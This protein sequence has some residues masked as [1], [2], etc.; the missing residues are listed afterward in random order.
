MWPILLTLALS[1]SEVRSEIARDEVVVFY[2]TYGRR[3]DDGKQ[4]VLDV[5]G[6]IFEPEENSLKRAALIG[7]LRRGLGLTSEHAETAIFRQRAQ[8]FLVDNEGNKTIHV[9]LGEKCY[10]SEPS[11]PNGHFSLTVTLD[12]SEVDKLAAKEAGASRHLTIRAITPDG[13]DREFT[14]RVNLIEPRGWSVIS[15]VD[16]TIKESNVTNPRVLLAN[17]FLREFK[18]VK[19]MSELYQSWAQRGA[20]FHYVSASPWQLFRPLEEFRSQEDF[21]AGS[22]QM[23]HFRLKDTS[24]LR[25]IA[26]QRGYKPAVLEKILKH[27]PE[28]KFV[29][30]GDDGEEDPEIYGELARKYPEQVLRVFIR[31]VIDAKSTDERF[32]KAFADVPAEKW[33]VFREPEEIRT[34]APKMSDEPE[35]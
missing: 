4:W 29:L 28:R 15:D 26:S 19:G 5:H 22:V 21:P 25:F 16:D 35:N 20:A 34:E 11:G 7:M 18:P 27:F 1:P 17:T 31:D 24:A 32:V 12:A 3:T 14:G 8:A 2:P 10:A 13:D 30:V 23:K 33:K 6:C 9:Q